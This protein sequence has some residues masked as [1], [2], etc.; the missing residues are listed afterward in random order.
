[1]RGDLGELLQFGIGAAQVLGRGVERGVV[2]A[3]LV[4]PA[5][6]ALTQDIDVA[7]ARR[8]AGSFCAKGSGV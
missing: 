5:D 3:R 1:M 6:D 8:P 2:F 4:E 7:A